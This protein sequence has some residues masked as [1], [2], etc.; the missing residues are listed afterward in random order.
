MRLM[1]D[2]LVAFLRV[3][4]QS[5]FVVVNIVGPGA[6]VDCVDC[7]VSDVVVHDCTVAQLHLNVA[8][9]DKCVGSEL[10]IG[11]GD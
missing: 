2:V 10:L 5:V 6:S 3:E 7:V 9:C 1:C 4:D 11:D 8:Q